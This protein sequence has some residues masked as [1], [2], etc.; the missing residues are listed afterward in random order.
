ML[1]D[2]VNEKEIFS[3]IEWGCGDG[4]Q[5]M[6]AV[7]PKYLGLDVSPMAVKMCEEKFK[8]NENYQ[9]ML[10][11]QYLGERCDLAISLDVIYHLIEDDVFHDY[12]DNLFSSSRRFIIIYAY[13]FVR[14]YDAPHEVGREFMVWVKENASQW[15]LI[16]KIENEF[17]YDPNDS[18]NTSQS[19]FYIFEATGT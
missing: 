4:N 18:S 14:H 12:M 9:F 15:T 3:I 17:P 1:N 6:L 13:N 2:F 11:K 10:T 16:E 19:D 7:Y 5:L 8:N